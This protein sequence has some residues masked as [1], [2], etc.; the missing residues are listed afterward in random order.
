MFLILFFFQSDGPLRKLT[1]GLFVIIQQHYVSE[2]N[3]QRQFLGGL[4][5]GISYSQVFNY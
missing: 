4:W 2:E 5:M 3:E 1:N